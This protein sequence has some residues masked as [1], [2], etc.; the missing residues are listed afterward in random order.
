MHMK[1]KL[2]R[3]VVTGCWVK[4]ASVHRLG[5]RTCSSCKVPLALEVWYGA[6]A[7]LILWTERMEISLVRLDRTS[8]RL[9]YV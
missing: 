8:P 7:G 2:I 3:G 1:V 6:F 4:E 5:A 9:W